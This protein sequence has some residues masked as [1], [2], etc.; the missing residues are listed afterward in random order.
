[1]S[2]FISNNRQ[3]WRA[4]TKVHYQIKQRFHNIISETVDRVAE[5]ETYNRY[6]KQI[7]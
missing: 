3:D 2:N 1:M 5:T 4:K 7:Y 6:N